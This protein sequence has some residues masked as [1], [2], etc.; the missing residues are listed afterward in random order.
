MIATEQELT[1]AL[2][3]LESL[4]VTEYLAVVLFSFAFQLATTELTAALFSLK[5]VSAAQQF[6]AALLFL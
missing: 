5:L 6:R 1:A 2:F 4:S 3:P